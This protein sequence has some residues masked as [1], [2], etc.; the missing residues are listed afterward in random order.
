MS[1]YLLGFLLCFTTMSFA[2]KIKTPK[3]KSNL[4]TDMRFNG[5]NVNG[6]YNTPGETA[7][8]IEEEKKL[9]SLISIRKHFR[10]RITEEMRRD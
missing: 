9:N 5:L 10:D 7:I 6:R 8:V 4:S 2:E 1:K 3:N